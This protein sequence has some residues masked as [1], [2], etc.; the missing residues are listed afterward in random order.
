MSHPSHA[1]VASLGDVLLVPVSTVPPSHGR[2]H[3]GAESL[4]LLRAVLWVWG[5]FVLAF[6]S[7]FLSR[8]RLM[9]SYFWLP[10]PLEIW[11]R[12]QPRMV[13]KCQTGQDVLKPP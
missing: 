5:L 2:G 7:P 6:F 9:F 13:L 1:S 11:Q 4:V 12:R 8:K 10:L 3:W